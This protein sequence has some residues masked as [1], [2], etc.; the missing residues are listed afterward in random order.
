MGGRGDCFGWVERVAMR[1]DCDPWVG[2][3][4]SGGGRRRI[5]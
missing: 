5:G 3:G 4:V 1:P 2:V